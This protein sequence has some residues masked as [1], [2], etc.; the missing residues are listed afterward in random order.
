MSNPVLRIEQ[1]RLLIGLIGVVE[2]RPEE[3]EGDDADDHQQSGNGQLVLDEDA[4]DLYAQPADV[5]RFATLGLEHHVRPE[6]FAHPHRDAG[7]TGVETGDRIL[8]EVLIVGHQF[9]PPNLMRG[10]ATA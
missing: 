3:A 9:P 5:G 10:S 1:S 4:E 2:V 8:D 6:G 7:R